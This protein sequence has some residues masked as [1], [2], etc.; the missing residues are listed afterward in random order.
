[1]DWDLGR[2]GSQSSGVHGKPATISLHGQVL[3]PP[4]IS[5][6]TEP[7]AEPASR[8]VHLDIADFTGYVW[9]RGRTASRDD[10][11]DADPLYGHRGRRGTR[12]PRL[13]RTSDMAEVQHRGMGGT[14]R[15][16]RLHWL[17]RIVGHCIGDGPK[18]RPGGAWNERECVCGWQ[19]ERGWEWEVWRV[20]EEMGIREEKG[21]QRHDGQA[22]R[23]G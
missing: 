16:G 13:M 9:G 7:E 18:G 14:S 10:G 8:G 21:R 12:P 2:V 5:N 23:R 4:C 15:R 20:A 17:C 11:L 1:M 22:G 19:R 6:T 3:Q